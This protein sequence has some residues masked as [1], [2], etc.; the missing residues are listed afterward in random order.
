[1][2]WRARS[3]PMLVPNLV[4]QKNISKSF[5]VLNQC[6]KVWELLRPVYLSFSHCIFL[7]KIVFP[8]CW[9]QFILFKAKLNP[10]LMANVEKIFTDSI[11]IHFY[12]CNASC[13]FFELPS[14]KKILRLFFL[15]QFFKKLIKPVW[16]QLIRGRLLLAKTW[17][18]KRQRKIHFCEDAKFPKNLNNLWKV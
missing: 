5:S 3:C 9:S 10:S 13:A 6:S 11:Q 18:A 1:M 14:P 15:K 16:K 17:A 2:W 12:R 8:C 4:D 7:R